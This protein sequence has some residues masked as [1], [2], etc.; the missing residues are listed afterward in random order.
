MEFEYK[1]DNQPPLDQVLLLYTD[2]QWTNYTK[3]PKQLQEAIRRSTYV[4]TCYHEQKLV[5]MLRVISDE[6]TIAYVQD[7]LVLKA[8]KRNGIGRKLMRKALDNYSDLR[9]FVLLTD[10]S[11]ETR[12]FYEALGFESCDKGKLVA[13]AKMN[14]D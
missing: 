6:M 7:I 11:S 2:A 3:D 4:L 10:D 1:R 13:F 8:Y 12:C 5:G 9:Q 14:N